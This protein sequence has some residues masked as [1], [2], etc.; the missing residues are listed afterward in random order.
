MLHLLCSPRAG[1]I[2]LLVLF[3]GCLTIEEHYTFKRDG[4]GT[5]TYVVDLSEMGEM[6]K[7]LEGM[8]EAAGETDG[9]EKPEMMELEEEATALKAISG[10]SKVKV[11]T[12]KEWIR[13]VTFAFK[14]LNALNEGLNT[15]MPDSTGLK[16]TF[17]TWEG[18]TLV[19]TSNR[20]ANELG[21]SMG[22]AGSGEEGEE[23]MDMGMLLGTMKYKYS[24]KFADAIGTTTSAEGVNKEEVSA[25]EVKLDTD[26]GVIAKD[27]HALDLR[28]QLN[29]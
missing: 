13:S 3:T 2:A 6:M 24:F 19:R 9:S 8:S 28:I 4:S 7:S 27:Q 15:L 5:M 25:R 16:H 20:F 21:A 10:I 11:S 17:F 14:D 26:W 22:E 23:G 29:K 18:N 12:K 1:V